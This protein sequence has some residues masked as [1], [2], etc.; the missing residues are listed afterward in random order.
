MSK[1]WK[2][3]NHAPCCLMK[4]GKLGVC[5]RK[6]IVFPDFFFNANKELYP[7]VV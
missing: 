2:F 6:G 7:G 5:E 1:D 4:E 3:P